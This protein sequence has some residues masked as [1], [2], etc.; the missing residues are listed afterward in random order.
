MFLS[1][2]LLESRS[3]D[4]SKALKSLFQFKDIVTWVINE[5]ALVFG[6]GTHPKHTITDY[7]NFFVRNIPESSKVLDLGSGYGAVAE[8]IA[9]LK[10]D[11]EIV[12]VDLDHTKIEDARRRQSHYENLK[13]VCGDAL[14]FEDERKF[15]III[16][17]NILEHIK[18]R[19]D[20]L[21]SLKTRFQDAQILVRVPLFERDWEMGLRKQLGVNYYSDADHKVEHTLIEFTSEISAAE[22]SIASLEI[23]WGEI[24]AVCR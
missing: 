24:W 2:V 12:G 16:L 1:L 21:S 4:S 23:K 3:G 18:D 13:F 15:D 11:C 9:R 17:S 7:H 19:V 22:L 20:F 8:S 5:R 10:P 6:G 14:N